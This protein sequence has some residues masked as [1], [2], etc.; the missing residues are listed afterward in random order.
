MIKAD[1]ILESCNTHP[2][3]KGSQVP[4]EFPDHILRTTALLERKGE[5]KK[6]KKGEIWHGNRTL[7]HQCVTF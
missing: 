1:I 6:K 3:R 4:Q 2:P 5:K 7:N